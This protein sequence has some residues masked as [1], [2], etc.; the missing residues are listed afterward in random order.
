MEASSVRTS[1]TSGSKGFLRNLAQ[2]HPWRFVALFSIFQFCVYGVGSAYE[3]VVTSVVCFHYVFAYFISLVVV[4]PVLSTGRFGAGIGVYI[5]FATIGFFMEYYME[6]V[7]TPNLIAPWAA[8]FW[9]VFGLMTG[10]SADL[11]HRFLPARVKGTSRGVMIGLVVGLADFC[12]TLAVLTFPYRDPV[13]GVLH[14]LY[15]WPIMLPYLL[16][17][18]AFAGYAANAIAQHMRK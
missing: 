14:L 18:A 15:G 10:F 11:M 6:W 13:S 12:L 4:V 3:L 5:P 2:N 16:V 9:S 17:S 7:V 8:V 1:Q